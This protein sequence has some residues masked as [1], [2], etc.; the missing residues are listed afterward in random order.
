MANSCCASASGGMLLLYAHCSMCF[1]AGSSSSVMVMLNTRASA[2]IQ[3][4]SS[5]LKY[6]DWPASTMPC[7]LKRA[8][9]TFSGVTSASWKS[10]RNGSSKWVAR[11]GPAA[12][13]GI[14]CACCCDDD[15]GEGDCRF[16]PFRPAC[17]GFATVTA[18]V[19][20]HPCR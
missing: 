14:C 17:R 16:I 2:P 15:D 19:C 6:P 8:S 7:T 1:A 11:S 13:C 18:V 20:A 3:F 9:S 5:D 12:Y 4:C 10:D